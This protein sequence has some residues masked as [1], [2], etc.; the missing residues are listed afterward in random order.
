MGYNRQIYFDTVR[1]SLFGGTMSQRQIDGQNAIINDW[2]RYY[3]KQGE[4]GDNRKLGYMLA[5]TYHETA[6][7]MWPIEEYGKGQGYS[8][9]EMDPETGQTYYG[10]GYVQLTWRDNY[11]DMT[12]RL[13]LEGTSQDMEWDAGQA[14]DKDLAARVMGLG[15]SQGTFRPP[16]KLMDYFNEVADDPYD[17]RDIINGDK[18]TVPSWANGVSIGN[19]IKAY[20]MDFTAALNVSETQMPAP[21]LDGR[22]VI[23]MNVRAPLGINVRVLVNGAELS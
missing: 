12:Q 15:M 21:S 10:R 22:V 23:S 9:G 8:Y 4:K 7:E 16:H 3:R 14:L 18:S 1:A 20:Y 19:L 5:T 6:Q 11:A 17:A 2:L 13:G